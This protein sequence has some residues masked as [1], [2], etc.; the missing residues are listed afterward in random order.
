M[1]R[2]H[3]V[4]AD[5]LRTSGLDKSDTVTDVMITYF[6]NDVVWAILSTCHMA[7]RTMPGAAIFGC[8]MLYDILFL[9]DWTNWTK[10]GK[11]IKRLSR[12]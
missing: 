4:L 3:G 8:D 9:A 12:L 5:M 2:I 6:L 7:L 10:L 11:R 1:E